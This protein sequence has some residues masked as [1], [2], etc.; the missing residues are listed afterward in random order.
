MNYTS[1]YQNYEVNILGC[2]LE[3]AR[4]IER[5]QPDPEDFEDPRHQ[6]I[7]RAMLR[8]K[9]KQVP[10]GVLEVFE[11][12][13]K[14]DL[15]SAA[16][17]W[18][19]VSNL[20][21]LATSPSNIEYEIAS[22]KE[23]AYVRRIKEMADK[24]MKARSIEEI[25]RLQ[26][27]LSEEDVQRDDLFLSLSGYEPPPRQWLLKPGFPMRYPNLIYSD[28]GVG[29][30]YFGLHLGTLAAMGGQTFLGLE[31]PKEPLKVLY[32]DWELEKDEFAMRKQE[33]ALGLD[34]PTGPDNLLYY[35]PDR[36]LPK[37]LLNFNGLL[38]KS[39]IQ[40]LIIDSLG[41]SCLDPDK[42][43]DVIEVFT[44]LK[45]LG[46]PTLIL[47][48]QPKMQAKE[49]Y[50]Q[51]TPYGTVYKSNLS[52]SVFQLACIGRAPGRISLML[53]HKKANFGQLLEDLRFDISFEGDRVRFFESMA[54]SPE[55]NDMIL[56]YETMAALKAGGERANQVTII[57]RLNKVLSRDRI[58][59]LLDKGVDTWW[60]LVPGLRHEKLYEQF[61]DY[62]EYIAPK[63]QKIRKSNGNGHL[64]DGG[65][66]EI[67]S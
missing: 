40:F 8:M 5:I 39:G 45:T 43:G 23:Q 62:P 25:K 51:K 60:K 24:L 17:D 10:I 15:L 21:Q 63:I 52:R 46:I 2:L 29:K 37:L 26:T 13:Q 33:V 22:I 53:T 3:D 38:K 57:A 20:K 66:P 9:E 55:E 18:D 65:Y 56:I 1:S 31:F 59:T 58:R 64:E 41:A 49:S 14:H 42:V 4:L 35:S 30:S 19:Y 34:L 27:K 6:V 50:N 36:S 47:D 54:L 28:G 16:G 11:Y 12:L 44:K 61:S 7:I 32:V 48:H 67:L